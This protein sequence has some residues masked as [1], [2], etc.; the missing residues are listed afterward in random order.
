MQFDTIEDIKTFYKKYAVKYGFGVRIQTSKKDDDNHLCYLKLV[1]LM[2]GKYVSQIL[3]ELKT[4]PTQ[5]KEC[6][7]CITT[8]KK[9]Q[10]WIVRTVVHEHNDDISPT[11]S[12]LIRWNRSLNLQANKTL[13]IND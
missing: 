1:C 12:M 3:L 2:E 11:K 13:D 10:A 8:V 4:H 7:T 6:P 9:P 5:R